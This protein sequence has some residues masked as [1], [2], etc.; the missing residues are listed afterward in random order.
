[1]QRH[2]SPTVIDLPPELPMGGCCADAPS[3]VTPLVFGKAISDVVADGAEHVDDLGH[4]LVTVASVEKCSLSPEDSK[5]EGAAEVKKSAPKPKAKQK[6]KLRKGKTTDLSTGDGEGGDGCQ[7]AARKP[8]SR[9]TIQV[10]AA[11]KHCEAEAEGEAE[12]ETDNTLEI[13]VANATPCSS[14]PVSPASTPLDEEARQIKQAGKVKALMKKRATKLPKAKGNDEDGVTDGDNENVSSS[15]VASPSLKKKVG[16]RGPG[17]K[18]KEEVEALVEDFDR[19]LKAKARA[20]TK[21][22]MRKAKSS[23]ALP[24]EPGT[25]D[26]GDIEVASPLLPTTSSLI[27]A[28]VAEGCELPTKQKSKRLPRRAKSLGRSKTES[29]I[30]AEPSEADS[31]KCEAGKEQAPVPTAKRRSQTADTRRK[32]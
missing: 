17:R 27:E 9:K 15:S 16:R 22:R 2:E 4:R 7:K 20:K 29:A 21:P 5:N 6:M 8:K 11:D 32:R 26:D 23:S 10:G 12:G 25:A 1:M 24:Q 19:K 28:E 14:P 13:D 18:I 3:P 30:M 31:A